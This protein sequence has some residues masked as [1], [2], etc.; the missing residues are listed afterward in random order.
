MQLRTLIGK[1]AAA[2]RSGSARPGA[3]SANPG[4]RGR[5]TRRG[6][7][8]GHRRRVRPHAHR[9]G[10]AAIGAGP[11][12]LNARERVRPSVTTLPSRSGRATARTPR[13][14]TIWGGPPAYGSPSCAR[15]AA[16]HPATRCNRHRR[17]DTNAVP[18]RRRPHRRRGRGSL[19]DACPRCWLADGERSSWQQ[20]IADMPS[21]PRPHKAA[22]TRHRHRLGPPASARWTRRCGRRLPRRTGPWSTT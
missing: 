21:S 5:G 12:K 16:T 11:G 15:A 8:P 10:T 4:G 19:C 9:P 2:G 3:R 17:R 14:P 18:A 6:D 22:V 20:Q 1:R 13:L 7:E